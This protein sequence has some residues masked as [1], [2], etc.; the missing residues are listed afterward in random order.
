M[1]DN[2]VQHLQREWELV[3]TNSAPTSNFTAQTVSLDLSGYAFIRI[4]ARC[5]ASATRSNYFDIPIGG[6][7]HTSGH[8]LEMFNTTA[9]ST[10]T[11]SLYGTRRKVTAT[12]TGVTFSTGY[13]KPTNN[14]N[15][16]TSDASRIIPV[17]IWAR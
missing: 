5:T 12:T 15:A 16:P 13:Y 10:S 3:W 14:T 11:G 6:S 17:R 8:Y 4:Q 7:P 1:A 9:T 2:L